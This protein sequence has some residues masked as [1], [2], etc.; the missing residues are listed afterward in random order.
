MDDIWWILECSVYVPLFER[1]FNKCLSCLYVPSAEQH[2]TANTSGRDERIV[3]LQRRDLETPRP[4]YLPQGLLE[5][6]FTPFVN[7]AK[8]NVY[9]WHI[10]QIMLTRILTAS[11]IRSAR[12]TKNFFNATAIFE[13]LSPRVRHCSTFS[14]LHRGSSLEMWIPKL[15]VSGSVH[16]GLRPSKTLQS[17][18]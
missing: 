3:Q 12:R 14:R 11:F 16:S 17:S 13:L 10:I 18:F 7:C 6:R 1:G 8:Y 5:S 4:I 2:N 15:H 9:R